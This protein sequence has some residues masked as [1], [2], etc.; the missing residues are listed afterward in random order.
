M[1]TRCGEPCLKASHIFPYW[2]LDFDDAGKR[3]FALLWNWS[4]DKVKSWKKIVVDDNGAINGEQIRN[5]ITLNSTA[6]LYWRKGLFALKP[7]EQGSHT[8]K[9]EFW[10]LP[11][12]FAKDL[13][14]EVAVGSKPDLDLTEFSKSP[15]N[16]I[17]L[18]DCQTEEVI[19]S[20]RVIT[21][22]TPDPE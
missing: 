5:V 19:E 8:L 3:F 9:V 22:T 17:K 10:W 21:I 14:R 15:G 12:I 16:N 20:G 11:I 2:L 7:L 6:Q 13:P 4:K 1:I 18:F